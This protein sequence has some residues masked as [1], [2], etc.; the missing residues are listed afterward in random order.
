MY[1]AERPCCLDPLSFSLGS[2]DLLPSRDN[3]LV[4][5]LPGYHAHHLPAPSRRLT[6]TLSTRGAPAL[7]ARARRAV[8]P[9]PKGHHEGRRHARGGRH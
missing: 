1:V 6:P 5:P 4:G 3:P 8:A 9:A 2:D 7:P